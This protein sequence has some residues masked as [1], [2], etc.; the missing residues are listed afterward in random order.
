MLYW[1]DAFRDLLFTSPDL[2]K[3]LRG[4]NFLRDC[5]KR[6]GARGFRGH[7]G[8]AGQ[9]G[10]SGIPNISSLQPRRPRPT[11]PKRRAFTFSA[12]TGGKLLLPIQTLSPALIHTA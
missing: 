3:A 4:G 11:G 12:L 5:C 10:R 8:A 6:L 7:D 1:A 9:R 2:E